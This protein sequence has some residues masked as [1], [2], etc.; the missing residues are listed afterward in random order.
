MHSMQK[1]DDSLATSIS[2]KAQIT[3]LSYEVF[4]SL[5]LLFIETLVFLLFNSMYMFISEIRNPYTIKYTLQLVKININIHINAIQ[6]M[7]SYNCYIKC[8]TNLSI[9]LSL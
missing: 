2:K 9:M 7:R 1:Y 3:M 5:Q 8:T 4:Y 6:S